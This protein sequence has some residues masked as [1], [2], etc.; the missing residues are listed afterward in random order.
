[1]RSLFKLFGQLFFAALLLFLLGTAS[2]AATDQLLE[3]YRTAQQSIYVK[4]YTEASTFSQWLEASRRALDVYDDQ[5]RVD[6]WLLALS[7]PGFRAEL[8]AFD[9]AFAEANRDYRELLANMEHDFEA[10]P[11][12][13]RGWEQAVLE[14][15]HA[16]PDSSVATVS[17]ALYRLAGALG[18]AV[19]SYG[20]HIRFQRRAESLE[21]DLKAISGG[22]RNEVDYMLG[23]LDSAIVGLRGDR[24]ME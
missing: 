4:P 2:V 23:P 15:Q 3:R 22:F 18:G 9:T 1:M 17:G 6:H 20:S 19:S 7:F 13:R 8:H 24:G 21:R 11:M 10:S 12:L 14:T 16:A 5:A